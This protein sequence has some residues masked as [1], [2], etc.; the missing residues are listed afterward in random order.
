MN[1]RITI[2]STDSTGVFSELELSMIRARVKSGL[3][4]AREKGRRIGR[5]P[6]TKDDIPAVF[7]KHFPAY[8]NGAMNV[9]EFARVCNLSRQTVYK[10]LKLV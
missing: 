3:A 8:A 1:L 10:Y 7:Y 5:R 4:N 9:S 6:T 2:D